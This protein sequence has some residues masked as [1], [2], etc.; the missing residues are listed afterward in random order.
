MHSKN[1]NL[2]GD[3]QADLELLSTVD[4][5]VCIALLEVLN[6]GVVLRMKLHAKAGFYCIM[7]VPKARQKWMKV[8]WQRFAQQI[9]LIQEQLTVISI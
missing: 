3:C 8:T 5:K 2:P 1:M 9:H 4:H 6:E 7:Q